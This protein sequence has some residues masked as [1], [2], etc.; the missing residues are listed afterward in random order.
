MVSKADRSL[1]GAAIVLAVLT[2]IGSGVDLVGLL[3]EQERLPSLAF[4]GYFKIDERQQ[5]GSV[6]SVM[7]TYY[8]RVTNKNKNSE[9]LIESCAGINVFFIA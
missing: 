9:G 4:D 7:T 3:R 6:E 2:W 5:T 1:V 8:V